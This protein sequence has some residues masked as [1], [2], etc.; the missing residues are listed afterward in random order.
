MNTVYLFGALRVVIENATGRILAVLDAIT[1]QNADGLFSRQY[2]GDAVA[3]AHL[4][5]ASTADE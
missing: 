5:W 3:S 4:A 1:R 2:I